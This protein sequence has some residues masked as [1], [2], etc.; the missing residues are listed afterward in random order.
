MKPQ[1]VESLVQELRRQRQ[2]L[3]DEAA[4]AEASLRSIAEDRQS[5]R[6]ERAQEECSA[7]LFDRLDLRARRAIESIDAALGRVADGTY[8]TCTVCGGVIPIAR[9]RTLPA[10]A[11]CVDCARTQETPRLVKGGE[12]EVTRGGLL[13]ADMSL[14]TDRELGAVLRQQARDDGRVDMEDLRVVCRRGVVYLDGSVS[15]EAERRV[16]LK[17][18]TDVAGLQE[19]VD[20]LHVDGIVRPRRRRFKRSQDGQPPSGFEPSATDDVVKSDEEGLTYIPPVAPPA[21]EED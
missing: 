2:A 7:P 6:E 17:L 19:V 4:A 21:D 8:G 20:R 14:L 13:P 18:I 3:F 12:T 15:S 11:L 16:L 10:T 5:E 1:E 9:L